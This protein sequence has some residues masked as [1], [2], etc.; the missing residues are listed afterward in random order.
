MTRSTPKSPTSTR[1]G[2][3]TSSRAPGGRLLDVA[4]GTGRHAIAFADLGY[5]VT[6]SDINE[7]LLAAGR[8]AAGD[9]I[10]FLQ[11]DMCDLHVD[12]GPF[13]LVTCLFDSIGYPQNDERIISALRSLGRHVGPG[14]RVVWE[15]LHAPAILRGAAPVRVR[16][17]TLRDG[18]DL[19][20]TSETTIDVERMLMHVQYELWAVNATV[21]RSTTS[22]S[23]RIGSSP[24]PRCACSRTPPGC[25]FERWCRPTRTARSRRTRITSS[26]SRRHLREG[27]R[28]RDRGRARHRRPLHVPGDA[29]RIRR[30]AARRDIARVRHHPG[31]LQPLRGR[32][33]RLEGAPA[34]DGRADTRITGGA[35]CPGRFDRHAARSHPDAT[36]A[37]SRGRTH[38][39][40]LVPDV[41]RGRERAVRLPGPRPRAPNE[42]VVPGSQRARRVG[43]P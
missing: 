9:R 3:C 6:A 11:G 10:R 34:R 32:I 16:R 33:G 29:P 12:G 40:R 41:R 26:P 27:R 15:F 42:A 36:R 39:S 35:R 2:S 4:C 21:R 31:W 17:L 18:R 28:D 14:G 25:R 37:P 19:V 23:R 7:E 22:S 1:R 8:A 43:A 20:R 13:D 24:L 5:D 30:A 38:R